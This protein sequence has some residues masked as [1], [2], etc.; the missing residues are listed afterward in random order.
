M[1]RAA[2]TTLIGAVAGLSSA[3]PAFADGPVPQPPPTPAPQPA[4][5]PQGGSMRLQV[6][7]GLAARGRQYVLTGTAVT[8]V[9]QV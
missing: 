6:L 2:L 3:V 7:G 9:G 1:R 4:P 8:V 5:A